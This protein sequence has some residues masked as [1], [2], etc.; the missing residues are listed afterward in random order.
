[1]VRGKAARQREDFLPFATGSASIALW[2]RH[3]LGARNQAFVKR[4]DNH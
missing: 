3:G 1:M 4:L 2:A